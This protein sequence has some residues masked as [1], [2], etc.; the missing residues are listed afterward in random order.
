M[1]K[2]RWNGSR[3]SLTWKRRGMEIG[4][5]SWWRR[6]DV[7]EPDRIWMMENKR[8]NGSWES[9]NDGKDY[10]KWSSEGIDEGKEEVE[11][12]QGGSQ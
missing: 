12:K 4:M 6:G 10:V 9:F 11:W 2:K 5:V 8:G 1:H 3:E 7:M